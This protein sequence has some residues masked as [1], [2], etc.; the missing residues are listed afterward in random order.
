MVDPDAPSHET[1]VAAPWLHWIA[2]NVP[3]EALRK[4]FQPAIDEYNE[5]VGIVVLLV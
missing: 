1:P 2:G 5:F 4:T 3:G